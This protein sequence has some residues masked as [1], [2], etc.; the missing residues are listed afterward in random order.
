MTQY[1]YFEPTKMLM[2]P[3][4]VNR[5]IGSA[6]NHWSL[7]R[8]MS[9]G[10]Y[11]AYESPLPS[12]GIYTQKIDGSRWNKMGDSAIGDC[13][14]EQVWN[15]V[16]LTEEEKSD[17]EQAARIV[18]ATEIESRLA[19]INTWAGAKHITDVEA[20]IPTLVVQYVNKLLALN[21]EINIYPY[22]LAD[23]VH[24]KTFEHWPDRLTSLEIQQLVDPT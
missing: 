16:E 20:E 10:L 21:S 6:V 22:V 8:Q 2:T 23:S 19:S 7:D 13:Y 11:P 3:E 4:Q 17:V 12:Y 24:L 9:I 1:Y 14:Y 18:V 5:N 15:V